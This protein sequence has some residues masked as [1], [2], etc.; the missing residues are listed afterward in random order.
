M[1]MPAQALNAVSTA[2]STSYTKVAI[3][4]H[5]S[6]AIL[7]FLNVFLG[8]LME[9]F[10]KSNPGHDQ[11]LFYHASFGSLIFGL[12]VFR[13][14]WRSTHKP[15]AL[16]SH[17]P[18]WQQTIAHVLHWVLYTLMFVVPLTGYLHRMAGGHPVSF[19]GMG[20][21]P[22]L[23]GKN[24]PLRLLTDTLHV[25]LVWVL[26]ILVVGHIGAALKHRFIDRDRVIQRM[27][28]V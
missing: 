26:C 13:L 5:W 15:P 17:I 20:D 22:V 8:F 6:I 19:F 2:R 27:L 7:I 21:L 12:A 25:T 28:G 23:I 9:T 16:P 4:M 10:P 18:S 1:S 24:E 3:A 14:F 11:V